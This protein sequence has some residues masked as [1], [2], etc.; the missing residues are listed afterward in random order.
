MLQLK[1]IIYSKKV[2]YNW[3]QVVTKVDSIAKF[4][5][6]FH[7]KSELQLSGEIVAKRVSN[8]IVG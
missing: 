6:L 3:L 8:W 4:L 5:N 7:T 1:G 2:L